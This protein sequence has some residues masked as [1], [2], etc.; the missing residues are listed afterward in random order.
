MALQKIYLVTHFVGP[1]AVMH[2]AKE[3]LVDGKLVVSCA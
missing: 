3:D 1:I 2:F